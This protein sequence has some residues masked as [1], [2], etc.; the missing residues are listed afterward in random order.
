MATMFVCRFSSSSLFHLI[1]LITESVTTDRL[2]QSTWNITSSAIQGFT[3]VLFRLSSHACPLLLSVLC[4]PCLS[5]QRIANFSWQ[6]H[7][8]W[9]M[10]V[11]IG[12][13]LLILFRVTLLLPCYHGRSQL[14]L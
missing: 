12:I 11:E 10:P 1:V 3:Y 14:L 7:D 13:A 9:I 4:C 5:V 2:L 6:I 8:I